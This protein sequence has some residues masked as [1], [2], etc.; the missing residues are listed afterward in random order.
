MVGLQQLARA[1]A[2]TNL[3]ACYEDV[4]FVVGIS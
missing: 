3:L 1:F 4:E 2:C